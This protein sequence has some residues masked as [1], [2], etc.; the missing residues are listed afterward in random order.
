VSSD[1]EE[2]RQ[3]GFRMDRGEQ[4]AIVKM[5]PEDYALALAERARRAWL[6][7][8]VVLGA[9]LALVVGW[10]I[11]AMWYARRKDDPTPSPERDGGA[12]LAALPF[13]MPRVIPI[14]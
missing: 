9:A 14:A 7:V 5:V 4:R 11:W 3:I 6:F 2:R 8:G 1:N 12:W 10:V 13:G